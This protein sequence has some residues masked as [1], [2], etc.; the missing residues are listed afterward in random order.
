MSPKKRRVEASD[1]DSEG[2]SVRSQNNINKI[3]K[4]TKRNVG[5]AEVSQLAEWLDKLGQVENSDSSSG[6][7]SEWRLPVE[8]I[9][10][11]II[12]KKIECYASTAKIVNPTNR[13]PQS[14]FSTITLGYV[15]SKRGSREKCDEKR[16]GSFL[17]LAVEVV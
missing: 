8:P 3:M 12:S 4:F 10:N 11:K 1:S 15:H 5:E 6:E 17:I 2:S 9:V 16:Q 7:D 14:S 13:Q